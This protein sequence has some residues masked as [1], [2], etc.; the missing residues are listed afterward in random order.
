MEAGIPRALRC[1]PCAPPS[2]R[3]RGDTLLDHHFLLHSVLLFQS[4][5]HR[6]IRKLNP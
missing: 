2:L 5:E 1:A 4:A 3:E 6:G